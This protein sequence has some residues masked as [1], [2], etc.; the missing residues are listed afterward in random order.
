[1]PHLVTMV[2]M[3]C[4]RIEDRP[5]IFGDAGAPPLMM[6][7]VADPPPLERRSSPHVLPCRTFGCFRSNRIWPE[8]RRHSRPGRL[9]L[10]V[11][12]TDADRSG[13][14][15]FLLVIHGPISYRFRD[16]RRKLQFF[17]SPIFDA[18]TKGFPLEF[19]NGG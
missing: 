6:R 15:N 14:C 5:N 8:I 10:E 18:T 3:P 7:G 16:F 13:I 9:S 2:L 17:P 19:C 4:A 12:R 1:M 11:I